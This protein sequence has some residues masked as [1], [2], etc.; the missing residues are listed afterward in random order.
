MAKFGKLRAKASVIIE[1][2]SKKKKKTNK[3]R[4]ALGMVENMTNI[5]AQSTMI[6]TTIYVLMDVAI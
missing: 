6:I 1:T 2:Q 3:T 4:E 5:M